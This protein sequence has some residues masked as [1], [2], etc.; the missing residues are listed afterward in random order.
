M[1]GSPAGEELVV[2]RVEEE[3]LNETIIG[4][5]GEEQG[6]V[7]TKATNDIIPVCIMSYIMLCVLRCILCCLIYWIGLCV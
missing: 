7:A 3:V 6:V 2:G 1:Y 5:E 4:V